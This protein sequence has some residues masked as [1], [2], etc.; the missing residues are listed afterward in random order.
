MHAAH[1][2]NADA[3]R[4]KQ[5]HVSGDGTTFTHVQTLQVDGKRIAPSAKTSPTSLHK[6]FFYL[7]FSLIIV[8]FVNILGVLIRSI[9]DI[10]NTLT[11]I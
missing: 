10:F 9:M 3:A 5:L 2:A 1:A 7:L 4:R 6:H 11:M 8:N